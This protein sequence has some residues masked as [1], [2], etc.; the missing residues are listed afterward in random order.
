MSSSIL[1]YEALI[2][3]LEN[4]CSAGIPGKSEEEIAELRTTVERYRHSMASENGVSGIVESLECQKTLLELA[5]QLGLAGE[6]KLRIAVRTDGKRIAT[7]LISIFTSESGEEEV[8]RLEDEAAQNF[9]DVVQNTL[10]KGFITTTQH[11]RLARRIIRKLSASC[12]KLPSSLFIGGVIE[13]E[14]H[15]SYGG[16]FADIYRASYKHNL[17]ALKY[18][19]AVQFLR[20]ADLRGI[21][22]KFCREALVW[23]ELCHP[24]ILPFLGIEEN[25]FPSPLCMVSPWMQH[26]TVIQYLKEHGHAKLDKLLHEIA[27]GLEYLHSCAIIHGDLRGANIL[28]NEDWRA[29][30][31]DFGLSIFSDAT[32]SLNTNRSGSVYWMAPELLD[33]DQFG[34]KFARTTA[35]DVYAYGCVCLEL[36]TG[37]P[38]FSGLTEAGAM[39]KVIGGQ[40]PEPPDGPPVMT[41]GLWEHISVFWAHDPT[42]RPTTQRMAEIMFLPGEP[43]PAAADT[44][45]SR[46][47]SPAFSEQSTAYWT[48]RS[49]VTDS[50]SVFSGLG[51]STS[52]PVSDSHTN[53]TVVL[54]KK[55][56]RRMTALEARL[57]KEHEM[58]LEND[59]PDPSADGEKWVSRLKD[60]KE[61]AD[62]MHW[63]LQMTLDPS[64]PASVHSIPTKYMIDA[65]MWTHAFYA[66]FESLRRAS[67][68]SYLA[69]ELLQ[70]YI[71]YAYTFYA[72]LLEDYALRDFEGAWIEALGDIAQ[73]KMK[74]VATAITHEYSVV[75]PLAST[76]VLEI[77]SVERLEDD[78]TPKAASAFSATHLDHAFTLSAGAVASFEMEPEKELWRCIARGWYRRGTL[79]QPS[80]GKLHYRLSRLSQEAE[81]PEQLHTLYHFCKSLATMHPFELSPGQSLWSDES[82]QLRLPPDSPVV[83]LFVHLHGMLFTG[84]DLD[85]FQSTLDQ[86]M[87]R[88]AVEELHECEWIMLAVVNVCA[89]LEYGSLTGVLKQ[90]S[91]SSSSS[92]ASTVG[93]HDDSELADASTNES[94]ELTTRPASLRLA[95]QLMLTTLSFVLRQSI[96]PDIYGYITVVLT[97]LTTALKG[98]STRGMIESMV[99]WHDLAMLFERI[100]KRIIASEGLKT[101]TIGISDK[102]HWETITTGCT[103]LPEDWCLR[104]MEWLR[105]R[106]VYARKFW[107]KDQDTCREMDVLGSAERVISFEECNDVDDDEQSARKNAELSQRWVRIARCGVEIADLVNDEYSTSVEVSASDGELRTNCY[108]DVATALLSRAPASKI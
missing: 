104:G 10:D 65:R 76:D 52:D 19:R 82:R 47:G 55:L 94:H 60:H 35:S 54:L 91:R 13:R 8:L 78:M 100:P 86:F 1:V 62:L 33:P 4:A 16:G 27:Q 2:L 101:I 32:S 67:S 57:I 72:C 59:L 83:T 68:I 95:L 24:N 14:E 7:L 87:T 36:Y 75:K 41:N 107:G 98:P 74:L 105:W 9:L 66:P 51:H 64:F 79:K 48:A 30:L 44:L 84:V 34:L 29:C 61:L 103:P 106:K 108:R 49:F 85:N 69:L 20:G 21:R 31:A 25:S 93:P 71:Q 97:F 12:D 42:A 102:R 50:S 96:S 80:Q 43:L 92:N 3:Y 22:A 37:R 28:I 38:P 40:R 88:L 17:V 23:K 15:P 73:Y 18:M 81:Q 77:A 70:D 6:P 26:G 11:C 90:A 63:L 53:E 45:Q 58:E 56:Y 46:P 39:L 89:V 99:P 5:S